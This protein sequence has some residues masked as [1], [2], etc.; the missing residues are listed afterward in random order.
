MIPIEIVNKILFYVGEL[1][2]NIVVTQY[3]PITKKEYYKINYNS[4]LLWRI[5]STL[6]MK[7]LYPIYPNKG[8]FMNKANMELYKFGIPHYEKNLREQNDYVKSVV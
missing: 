6:V 7:G 4:A 2:N 8:G 5:K 3:H 1:N